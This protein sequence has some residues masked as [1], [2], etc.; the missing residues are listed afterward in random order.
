[1]RI[2]LNSRNPTVPQALLIYFS[3]LFFWH[4]V[5]SLAK[6]DNVDFLKYAAAGG[7]VYWFARTVKIPDFFGRPVTFADTSQITLLCGATILTGVGLWALLVFLDAVLNGHGTAERWGLISYR[8]F[9]QL[10]WSRPWLIG[11]L[12]TSALIVPITEE[13]VFRGFVLGRLLERNGRATAVIASS[14]IFAALHFDKSFL[15]T[16]VHGLIFAVLAIQTSSLYAPIMVHGLYNAAAFALR[17][18]FGFS[19]VADANMLSRPDYW[20]PELLCGLAGFALLAVYF[21][22]W[23]FGRYGKNAK[24]EN[25]SDTSELSVLR[26]S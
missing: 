25:P 23:P 24:Q 19:I 1:M 22:V 13:I 17:V 5:L 8:N 15:G 26:K 16:F 3:I 20:I 4:F 11:Y 9:E 14:A 2:A 10:Q 6:V 12:L 21:F 7:T 18:L